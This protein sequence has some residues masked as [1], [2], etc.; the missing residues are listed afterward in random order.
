MLKKLLLILLPIS[1][2]LLLVYYSLG[3]FQAPVIHLRP[4]DSYVVAGQEYV[5]TFE[6]DKLQEYFLRMKNY[7]DSG[8]IKGRVTVINYQVGDLPEDSIHQLIGIRLV[9]SASPPTDLL[10][11]T[12]ASGEVVRAIVR[13]HPLVR[14]TPEQTIEMITD[15]AAARQLS[16]E[17]KVIEQYLEEDELWVEIPVR[18]SSP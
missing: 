4:T 1:L 12:I 14:P 15:Y 6:Y 17:D 10:T 13:A 16:L 18:Q 9:D 7:L 11:D 8:V 3:G 5:G 2:I